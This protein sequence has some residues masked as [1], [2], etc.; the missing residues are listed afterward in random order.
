MPSQ[1]RKLVGKRIAPR[2]VVATA[3]L[4]A[5]ALA[6]SLMLPKG[7]RPSARSVTTASATDL[8]VT[9]GGSGGGSG[10][11]VSVDAGN[12]VISPAVSCSL[13]T[14]ASLTKLLPGTV[15]T[16]V[17]GAAVTTYNGA[18]YCSVQVLIAPQTQGQVLLPVS[19]WTGDYVQEGCGGQC[20]TVTVG[21][22]AAAAGCA[23]VT[24]NQFVLASDDEG[25][26]GAGSQF[27]AY[28]TA[29]RLQFAYLSEH[30]MAVVAKAV[31]RD[32]YDRAPVYSYYDGCSTGG[33]EAL[34]EAER[35]PHDFNGILAG[36]PVN[37][38]LS[39]SAEE[40]SW[41]IRA[42]EDSSGKEILTSAQ[43][44]ALHAAVMAAC[45]NAQGYIPDPRAC[46]FN[47]A[48]IQC[49]AGQVTD[50][51]LTAAQVAAADR[52]Y[53]GPTNAQG[54]LLYPGGEPYGSEDSWAGA[55]IEPASDTSWPGDTSLGAFAATVTAQEAL[56]TT[57]PP[58]W[59][60]NDWRY[61]DA[62]FHR[63]S[64]LATFYD[65][66]DPDLSAFRAAGGKLI[67]Y[68]GWE[69]QQAPPTATVQ[70]YSHV[71]KDAGG[72]AASQAFTRL[73]M[74]PGGYHCLDGGSPSVTADLLTPLIGWVEAG[75]SPGAETFPLTTPTPELSAITVSPLNPD[76]PPAGNGKGLN[77]N[78]S[79]YIGTYPETL[80]WC[81]VN[82]MNTSCK[83]ARRDPYP[84]AG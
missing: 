59:T 24:A 43:L 64:Q 14:S 12:A 32:Y 57:L 55:F 5:V 45:A 7:A 44:P 80:M 35:Y 25:H 47:P 70:Y 3:V 50:S 66:I 11:K 34:A 38:L 53:R 40:H 83:K 48:S 21:A 81:E 65:S 41:I 78:V 77:S 74:I 23:P 17:T 22:P 68:Q 39:L 36:S 33:R 54:K 1:S 56:S 10:S 69:D 61:N 8:A 46:D 71:V 27:A 49:P 52:I 26:T 51:C 58:S 67:I 62:S 82:G 60:I 13:I 72:F 16:Q 79:S 9:G 63:L 15:L 4:A 37:D 29:L 6:V 75:H 76:T 73:Y 19:T 20:G 2:L 28:D 18:Q 84:D 30:L 31:I 42:N